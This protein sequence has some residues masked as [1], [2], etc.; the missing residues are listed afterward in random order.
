MA[1]ISRSQRFSKVSDETNILKYF[2]S[3]I[4]LRFNALDVFR[5][6]NYRIKFAYWEQYQQRV[7][8]DRELDVG[9]GFPMRTI[10]NYIASSK[11]DDVMQKR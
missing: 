3:K 1:L 9:K 5:S 11:L 4:P 6:D 2:I 10:S 8:T 7:A